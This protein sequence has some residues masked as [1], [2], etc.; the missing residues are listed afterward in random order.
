MTDDLTRG[1]EG[2]QDPSADSTEITYTTGR[3]G[4]ATVVGQAA[5]VVNVSRPAAGQTVEIQAAAGQTYNLDFPPAGAQVQL[6]GT[7]FILA[8]EDGGQIVFSDMAT[9]VEGGDAPTFTLA[10]TEVSAEVLLT[11]ALALAGQDDATLE[12]AAAPD[13]LGTG[14]T[15]YVDFLGNLIDLL[16]AQ[17]VIPPV[18]LEFGLIDLEEDPFALT[19]GALEEQST[20]LINEIGIAVKMNI[21]D[22]PRE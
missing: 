9:V 3:E 1:L 2:Q 16:I 20:P 19:T 14:A 5:E 17:G 12:T 11:Q 7:D 6:D 18:E 22:L 21:P 13:A 10:G 8:F 4:A 15:V